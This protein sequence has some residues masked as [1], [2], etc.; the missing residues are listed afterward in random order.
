LKEA[1]QLAIENEILQ[2]YR[3]IEEDVKDHEARI[4][5]LEVDNTA[6]KLNIKDLRRSMDK[7]ENNTTWILRLVIGGIV[8]ALLALLIKGGMQ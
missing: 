2:K 3:D 6:H 7:I 5:I 4:R 1:V 8:S